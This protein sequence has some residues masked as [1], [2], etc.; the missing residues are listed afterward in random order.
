M[1]KIDRMHHC[2]KDTVI[3]LNNK[4]VNFTIKVVVKGRTC[5]LHL[6]ISP[7]RVHV[8][9]FILIYLFDYF[10]KSSCL[11]SIDLSSR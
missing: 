4:V 2:H 9:G 11:A 5:V 10:G 7:I 1:V 3:L 8:R 6:L